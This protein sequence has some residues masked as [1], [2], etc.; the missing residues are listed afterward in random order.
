MYGNFLLVSH[1]A[2]M[3]LRK[4]HTEKVISQKS[5]YNRPQN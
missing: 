1:L 3:Y 2:Y 4:I 5:K